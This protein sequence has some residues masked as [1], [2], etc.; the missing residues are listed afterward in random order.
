MGVKVLI[1]GVY[2]IDSIDRMGAE[3]RSTQD[4]TPYQFTFRTGEV[5]KAFVLVGVWGGTEGTA[6]FDDVVLREDRPAGKE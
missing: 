6:W 1:D 2:V 3:L 5:S 4:W